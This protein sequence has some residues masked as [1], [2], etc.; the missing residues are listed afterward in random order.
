MH[1]LQLCACFID[2]IEVRRFKMHIYPVARLA[3]SSTN[4]VSQHSLEEVVVTLLNKQVKRQAKK[5]SRRFAYWL[6]QDKTE[7]MGGREC[8]AA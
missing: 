7:S 5:E 2:F 3:V 6:H 8:L 1:K 4:S